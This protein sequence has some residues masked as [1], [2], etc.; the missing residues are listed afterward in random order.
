MACDLNNNDDWWKEFFCD[1]F[2]NLLLERN[3]SEKLAQ[4]I[5]FITQALKL[6]TGQTV[7]DQCCGTGEITCA[8]AKKGIYTIGVDQNESYIA[9]A[10]EKAKKSQL[11][12][13]FH[14]GDAFSFRCPKVA[15]AAINWYSS[16][17]Y[18]SVDSTNLKMLQMIYIS[19][20]SGGLF[21]LDYYNPAYIFSHFV[22]Y[23]VINKTTE[24]GVITLHKESTVDL[25][26]GMF[27]SSWRFVK[28]HQ[29]EV[30]KTGESRIYFAKDLC[31]MLKSCGFSIVSIK[32]DIFGA[33]LSLD[34]PRCII[35]AQK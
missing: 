33:P 32:G 35:T 15:D 1:N 25:E 8:L 27:I 22:K 23:Q 9:K 12:C 19:L 28:P 10:K 24:N 5:A 11:L 2:A 31:D 4:E 29:D 26:R 7:F 21:L 16:F 30:T 20:K 6:E 34:S 14:H 18:S 3:E 13:D 17:G